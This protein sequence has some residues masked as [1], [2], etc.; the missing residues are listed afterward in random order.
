MRDQ[1][2]ANGSSSAAETQLQMRLRNGGYSR[3]S[4]NEN[5]T[6]FIQDSSVENTGT[7]VKP[8][9]RYYFI[10]EFTKPQYITN[11]TFFVIQGNATMFCNQKQVL[12]SS[13]GTHAFDKNLNAVAP[14]NLGS[15]YTTNT[16]AD[17]ERK[18]LCR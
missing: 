10:Y 14:I 17:E 18:Y 15:G 16:L 7:K 5:V 13:F 4:K 3:V 6:V 9:I 11:K 1:S 2:S 12:Y 8:V